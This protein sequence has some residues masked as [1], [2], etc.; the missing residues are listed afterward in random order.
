MDSAKESLLEA[1]KFEASIDN[2]KA[3]ILT[4]EKGNADREA[5]LKKLKSINKKLKDLERKGWSR[6]VDIED[7]GNELVKNLERRK[8]GITVTTYAPCDRKEIS[9]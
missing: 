3:Q 6:I 9:K 2:I 4:A 8:A 5:K 7:S 1:K